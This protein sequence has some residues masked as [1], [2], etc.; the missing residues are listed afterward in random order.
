MAGR[1]RI[2]LLVCIEAAATPGYFTR[3]RFG[4]NGGG[5][6]CV[7]APGAYCHE[8]SGNPWIRLHAT[9]LSDTFRI[10]NNGGDQV[11]AERIGV[12]GWGLDLEVVCSTNASRA[13]IAVRLGSCKDGCN[14]SKGACTAG[15]TLDCPSTAGDKD[16]RVN[17]DFAT[18]SDSFHVAKHGQEVCARRLGD[19]DKTYDMNLHVVCFSTTSTTTTTTA[20]TSTRTSTTSS[21]SISSTSTSTSSTSSTATTSSTSSSTTSRTAPELSSAAELFG[22]LS[23]LEESVLAMLAGSNAAET[24]TPGA[25]FAVTRL[26]VVE[27]D[28]QLRAG[29]AEL[30]IPNATVAGLDGAAAA[31]LT[32]L[33]PELIEGVMQPPGEISSLLNIN[34]FSGSDEKLKVAGVAEPFLVTVPEGNVTDCLYWHEGRR[35]W[36]PDGISIVERAN[37]TLTFATTHLTLFA[38]IVRGFVNAILCAQLGLLSRDGV[39]AVFEG[40]WFL[41]P[42]A[43]LFWGILAALLAVC[44][45]SCWLDRLPGHAWNDEWFLV[46]MDNAKEEAALQAPVEGVSSRMAATGTCLCCLGS[47]S[48]LREALDDICSRWCA[49]FGEAR[50]LLEA[51]CS[52]VELHAGLGEGPLMAVSTTVLGSLIAGNA[53]R[54][55]AYALGLS[56]DIVS[57]VLED[58][59][60]G[61]VLGEAA[62]SSVLASKDP[63]H[64]RMKAWL[65][66]HQQILQEID[67]YW[68]DTGRWCAVPS[69]AWKIFVAVNPLASVFL[70]CRLLPHSMRVLLYSCELLGALTLAAL[71]YDAS[72]LA[73]SKRASRECGDDLPVWENLGRLLAITAGS[74]LLA[75]LPVSLIASLHDRSF[76]KLPWE[77]CPEWRRRLQ[78]WAAQDRI[79]WA[80]GLLY[81]GF[82][83]TFIVLFLANVAPDDLPNWGV[84][85]LVQLLEEMVAIPLAVG[86][87]VPLLATA[88]LRLQSRCRRRAVREVLRE[89]REQRARGEGNWRHMVLSI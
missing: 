33:E 19:G 16:I 75:E 18:A 25:A 36:L 48:I 11:C 57:F 38:A 50:D 22:W 60:L 47:G 37:G 86:L 83:C 77:G 80:S 78:V 65:H 88:A 8:N 64:L 74:L 27:G 67:R 84:G 39:A 17:S 24:V 40:D 14:T 58:P 72:G 30:A 61:E 82:C 56:T 3:V 6:K 81:C 29:G 13:V 42:F 54:Q 2:L 20:S 10:Y 46:P 79:L 7:S 87:A 76:Q 59:D 35:E 70:R 4:S 9:D 31:L 49:Y 71:F 53:R 1:L 63:R 26:G 41:G 32:V 45:R 43:L 85:T 68:D 44:F 21:T 69:G 28:V 5:A 73:F 15:P 51:V 23:E 34:I 66:L 89:R 12:S 62:S 55:A 52:E